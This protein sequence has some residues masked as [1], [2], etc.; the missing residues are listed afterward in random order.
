MK[1]FINDLKQVTKEDILGGCVV[2]GYAVF[3]YFICWAFSI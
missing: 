1:E 2:V 3:A